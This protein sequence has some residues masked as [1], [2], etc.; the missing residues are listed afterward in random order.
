MLRRLYD[1]TLRL[2]R[3][4]AAERWLAFISFIESS[5]FPVPPD[6]M[7]GPMA[8]AKPKRAFRYAL[9]C[10]VASVLGGL[11]GYAIGFFL[12]ET[13]G[14]SVIAFYGYED[15]FAEFAD[16]FNEQGALLVFIFGLTFFPFKVITIAS[17]VTMLDP[18]VFTFA[19]IASRAPRFFI[20]A[21]LLWKFGPPIQQF[22]EKRLAL[23]TSLVVFLGVAGFVLLK[24]L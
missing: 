1:W 6:V 24:Y 2:A 21:A 8:L 15:K 14:Q 23:I 20:E 7:L 18:V 5:V 12:W 9:I 13:V 17:G 11:A 19:A 16:A 10:T 3:H 4:P 22:V